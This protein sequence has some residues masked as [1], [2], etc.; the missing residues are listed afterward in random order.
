MFEEMPDADF[1]RH[2]AVVCHTLAVRRHLHENPAASRAEAWQFAARNW[3]EFIDAA[4]VFLA[5]QAVRREQRA[6][7]GPERK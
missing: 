6:G 4:F 1:E 7:D 2:V 3:E 5:A